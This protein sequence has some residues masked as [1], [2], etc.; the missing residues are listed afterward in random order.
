MQPYKFSHTLQHVGWQALQL[1]HLCWTTEFVLPLHP[2]SQSSVDV[3]SINSVQINNTTFICQVTLAIRLWL[4][5]RVRLS[6]WISQSKWYCTPVPD[7]HAQLALKFAFSAL[8]LLVG[9]QEEHPACKYWV[10]RY[11]HG[12]LSGVRCKLFA[13]GP[14]DATATPS[15][16][17]AVKARIVYHSSAGLPRLS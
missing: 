14:A 1:N 12:Y 11:W 3:V 8:M 6:I 16:L 4:L 7:V 2:L 15:S 5:V 9:W 10:V 17:A 13:C